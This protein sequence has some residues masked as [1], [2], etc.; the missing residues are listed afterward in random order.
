MM[1][2][3]PGMDAIKRETREVYEEDQE[4]NPVAVAPVVKVEEDQLELN[5]LRFLHHPNRLPPSASVQPLVD[6][7]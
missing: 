6:A 1:D 4:E 7:H 5:H 2:H 3:S